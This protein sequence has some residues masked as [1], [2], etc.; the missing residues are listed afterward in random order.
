MLFGRLVLADPVEHFFGLRPP[1][2]HDGLPALGY[3]SWVPQKFAGLVCQCEGVGIRV[4]GATM[5]WWLGTRM[6]QF[7]AAGFFI[8]G[9][10]SQ[11]GIAAPP[12]FPRIAQK[13]Q[14]RVQAN[15]AGGQVADAASNEDVD[16][17][18]VQPR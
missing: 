10:L 9:I 4:G 11:S 16:A 18:F 14:I 1:T 8:L 3:L 7:F 5:D 15:V 6:G 2:I 13:A 12:P 17:N